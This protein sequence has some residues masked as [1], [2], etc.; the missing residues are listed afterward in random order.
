[1][2]KI[3]SILLLS[4]TAGNISAQINRNIK[5]PSPVSATYDNNG[6]DL[7]GFINSN[8]NQLDWRGNAV[9]TASG[10]KWGYI[11]YKHVKVPG[12]DKRGNLNYYENFDVSL[13]MYKTGNEAKATW[14]GREY[15]SPNGPMV[16]VKADDPGM[17]SIENVKYNTILNEL[18]TK[19][20]TFVEYYDTIYSQ[21][22]FDK[23]YKN[24]LFV[25]SG[26]IKDADEYKEIV[27]SINVFLNK[28]SSFDDPVLEDKSFIVN[29]GT[30]NSKYVAYFNIVNGKITGKLEPMNAQYEEEKI[31]KVNDM[32]KQL[33]G[34]Y[35]YTY[36]NVDADVAKIIRKRA[37]KDNIKVEHKNA[38]SNF[39]FNSL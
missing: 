32:F 13:I 12:Q 6:N 9:N 26:I 20:L 21:S 39:K 27:S 33:T 30:S 3:F 35:V 31:K 16:Y 15:N 23:L 10:N 28:F 22:D 11:Q 36:G 38:T 37:E 14:W 18:Q 17:L 4:I 7:R 1:M 19:E 25:K 5:F 34:T 24:T 29:F 8:K 2:K